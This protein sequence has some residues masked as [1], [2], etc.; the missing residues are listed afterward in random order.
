MKSSPQLHTDTFKFL[1]ALRANNN[2]EWFDKNRKT[3]EAVKKDFYIFVEGL[4]TELRKFNTDIEPLEAK[5]CV[6][7]INRDIR[8]SKDKSP[9]KSNLAASIGKGGKKSHFAG[10]Y[11]HVEPNGNTFIGGGVW[12]PEKDVLDKVRQE[13]DYNQKQFEKIVLNK[14]FKNIF[15]SMYDDKISTTP[16]NYAKDNPAIEWLKYRSYIFGADIKKDADVLG[17][18]AL[19]NFVKTAKALSPFIQFINTAI[20]D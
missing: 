18:N 7:R 14:S 17:K 9:Y 19:S 5:N 13:I 8:F 15:G 2:K 4:I 20:A 16:K 11:F 1:K 12:H 6:F 3:Y 10:Y